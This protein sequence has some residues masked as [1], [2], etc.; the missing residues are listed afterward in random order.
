MGSDLME[1]ADNSTAGRVIFCCQTGKGVSPTYRD[2]L[3]IETVLGS[4]HLSSD[5]P[6]NLFAGTDCIQQ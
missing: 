6:A 2:Q 1:A 5:P 4:E 3:S